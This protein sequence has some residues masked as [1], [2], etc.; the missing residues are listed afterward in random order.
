MEEVTREIEFEGDG[1]E[2][3]TTLLGERKTDWVEELVEYVH[4]IYDQKWAAII[5]Y[6]DV[7]KSRKPRIER[8]IQKCNKY[9]EAHLNEIL[10]LFESDPHPK[11]SLP[12]L[13]KCS[14]LL[15]ENPHW[16][17]GLVLL[18]WDF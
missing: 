16:E 14:E 3:M 8:S 12:V 10:A 11:M 17:T 5:K 15:H 6:A 1:E 9:I 13:V 2:D 4:K 18:E 7:Q